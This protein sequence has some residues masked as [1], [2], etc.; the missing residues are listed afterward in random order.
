VYHIQTGKIKNAKKIQKEVR[1]K[2]I[3]LAE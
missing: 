3:L 1:G 2:I